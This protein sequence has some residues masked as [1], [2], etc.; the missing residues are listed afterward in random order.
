[1]F[2][3]QKEGNNFDINSSIVLLGYSRPYTKYMKCIARLIHVLLINQ[4]HHKI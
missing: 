2:I 4:C 1:M 3:Y